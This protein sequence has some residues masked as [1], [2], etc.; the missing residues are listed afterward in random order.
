VGQAAIKRQN[1]VE[2]DMHFEGVHNTKK[3]NKYLKTCIFAVRNKARNE[4]SS[5][6][7]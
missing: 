3:Y 7:P 2:A 4:L 1:V 5:S 6:K